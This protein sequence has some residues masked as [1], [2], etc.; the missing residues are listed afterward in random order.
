MYVAAG[1]LFMT[2]CVFWTNF[3]TSR[4]YDLSNIGGSVKLGY[5]TLSG[6]PAS[7]TTVYDAVSGVT[8]TNLSPADPLFASRT[9]LHLK[10]KGGRWDPA[11][12]GG[13]GAWT[14]DAVTSPC[15]DAGDPASPYDQEPQPNGR[16]INLGFD[17]NTWQASMPFR[18]AG[19]IMVIH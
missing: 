10:S 6:D 8:R 16:R 13:A 9:D 11:L 2:N 3:A 12:A 19:T 4:G 15:I 18:L 17:G 1:T 7:T 14:N 5:C